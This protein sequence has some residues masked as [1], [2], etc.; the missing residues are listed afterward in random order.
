MADAEHRTLA[1]TN[2]LFDIGQMADAYFAVAILQL[3]ESGAIALDDP[4]SKYLNDLP[5]SARG[6]TVRQLVQHQSGLRAG[7][8]PSP[9]FE[10]GTRSADSPVDYELL[11]RLIA[12]AGGGSCEKFV[13]DHRFK[14]PGLDHTFFASELDGV[15]REKLDGDARHR[16]FLKNPRLID[17][18]EPATGAPAETGAPAPGAIYASAHDISRWDVALAGEVLIKDP[19]LRKL[20]YHP[21]SLKDGRATPTSGPW[22]FPG[23]PGLMISTGS[24][25]GFSSL[26]SRFTQPDELV[27]VTLLANREGMDLTQL[28]RKIAGA[29]DAKIGPP[30]QAAASRVQQSPYPVAET[31]DRLEKFSANRERR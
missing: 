24:A 21:A 4:I 14:P 11:R 6:V 28:A 3:V 30:P 31:I 23:H 8:D 20:I 12:K 2:T 25:R 22:I 16:E 10:P 26:P 19:A 9:A 13:R 18:T 17:P 29:Y 7:G 5:A 27:C 15:A 1:S